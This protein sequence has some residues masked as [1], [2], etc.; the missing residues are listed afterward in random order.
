MINTRSS[1]DDIQ[2]GINMINT[3]VVLMIY[4]GG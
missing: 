2:G 3:P 4:K 1:I